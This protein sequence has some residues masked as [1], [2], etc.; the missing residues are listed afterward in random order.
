[1]LKHKGKTVANSVVLA[2]LLAARNQ[3]RNALLGHDRGQSLIETELIPRHVKLISD[4]N[5]E[6]HGCVPVVRGIEETLNRVTNENILAH[7]RVGQGVR[8]IPVTFNNS[9]VRIVLRI[10][11]RIV[12]ENYTF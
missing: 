2:S 9:T 5:G 3:T 12:F 1:M 7:V 11:L 10:V 6:C 8:F 4:L